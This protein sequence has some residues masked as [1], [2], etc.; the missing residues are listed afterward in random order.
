MSYEG[1]FSGRSNK[2]VDGCYSFWQGGASAIASSFYAPGDQINDPWL[3]RQGDEALGFS[4]LFDAPMLERYI[5]LCA[6]GKLCFAQLFVIQRYVLTLAY[7]ILDIRGGLR[8]KPSKP[9]DF[10]HS[11]YNLSGL[12][13]AQ[14]CDFAEKAYGDL[15]QTRVARTHPCY[16]IRIDRVRDMLQLT[17]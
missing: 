15:E 9:R 12:S 8:D 14:H 13:V 1:G 7:S 16:N 5:L 10:Y 2:L 3:E 17:W 6:Q 11:C 4:L